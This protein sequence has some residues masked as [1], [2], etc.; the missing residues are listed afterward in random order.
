MKNFIQGNCLCRD[1]MPLIKSMLQGHG[2][3]VAASNDTTGRWFVVQ[4]RADRGDIMTFAFKDQYYPYYG[5]LQ[6]YAGIATNQSMSENGGVYISAFTPEDNKIQKM[7]TTN[8]P[9]DISTYTAAGAPL[10]YYTAT[11][12]DSDNSPVHVFYSMSFGEDW[13]FIKVR[14]NPSVANAT[15]NMHYFGVFSHNSTA[16]VDIVYPKGLWGYFNVSSFNAAFPAWATDTWTS[17]AFTDASAMTDTVEGG[18]YSMLNYYRQLEFQGLNVPASTTIM[19]RIANDKFIFVPPQNMTHSSSA[20]A[21]YVDEVYAFGSG[22]TKKILYKRGSNTSMLVWMAD[23][24]T[25][26]TITDMGNGYKVSWIN[27]D[28]P[29]LQ[30][31]EIWASIVKQPQTREEADCVMIYSNDAPST[32]D[33]EYFIDDDAG[34]YSAENTYYTVIAKYD[35]SP[36]PQWTYASSGC[37]VSTTR[38]VEYFIPGPNQNEFDRSTYQRSTDPDN[39]HVYYSAI[40]SVPMTDTGTSTS[41]TENSGRGVTAVLNSGTPSAIQTPSQFGTS[42]IL[43]NKH[44]K[45][46]LPTS[47]GIPYHSSTVS[48]WAKVQALPAVAYHSMLV[49][50]GQGRTDGATVMTSPAGIAYAQDSGGGYPIL[51]GDYAGYA[52]WA[53]FSNHAYYSTVVAYDKRKEI[54]GNWFHYVL[55]IYGNRFVLY[56]NN[57]VATAGVA[58]A[59]N[60]Y[61]REINIGGYGNGVCGNAIFGPVE[62]FDGP[63]SKA[64]RDYLW[65]GGAGRLDSTEG[66]DAAY[67]IIAGPGSL[68]DS[69]TY[70]MGKPYNAKGKRKIR[71]DARATRIGANFKIGF[72]E[73]AEEI[74]AGNSMTV[75]LPTLGWTPCVLDISAVQDQFKDALQFM[76][77][78][79]TNDSATNIISIR[80][81]SAYYD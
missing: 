79:I 33:A 81:I 46:T 48:L 8:A 50:L 67:R 24:P 59:T 49:T 27:P 20:N 78:F 63:A 64:Q 47:V 58:S 4:K 35:A 43:A 77:I 44:V 52:G 23:T 28:L 26:T 3:N 54:L 73:T 41:L 69:I 12:D 21:G 70:K 45:I 62:I 17:A 39:L 37:T 25:Q 15:G 74:N 22:D 13:F 18:T 51:L 65:N 14:G 11:K 75:N 71:F 6:V 60:Y 10:Q 16:S 38:K 2:W 55:T 36:D 30:R 1:L 56:M 31:I 53:V 19:Y 40:A 72:G 61:N 32:G 9:T 5:N 66:G 29:S 42:L 68:N 80:N 7:W 76:K 34:R 57:E